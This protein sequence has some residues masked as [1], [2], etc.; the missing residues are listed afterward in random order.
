MFGEQTLAQLRTGLR[1]SV[2]RK[3]PANTEDEVETGKSQ[4]G[5]GNWVTD[6]SYNRTEFST[7]N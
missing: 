3:A 2:M 6:I 4:M 1:D 5:R 7:L